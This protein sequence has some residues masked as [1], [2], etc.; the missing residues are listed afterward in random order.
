MTLKTCK[1]KRLKMKYQSN[2]RLKKN[3]NQVKTVKFKDK[4]NDK[5]IAKKR[6]KIRSKQLN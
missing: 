1:K 5:L 4:N 6:M 3:E 2:D